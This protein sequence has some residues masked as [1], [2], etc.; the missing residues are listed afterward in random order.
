[1]TDGDVVIDG[2]GL[3]EAEVD[4]SSPREHPDT[5]ETTSS[6]D[7]PTTVARL[8]EVR[9]NDDRLCRMTPA[10]LRRFHRRRTRATTVT[11]VTHRRRPDARRDI[12]DR[13]GFAL[14]ASRPSARVAA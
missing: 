4:A 7:A 3:G 1:M 14:T 13:S 2:V 9:Q 6:E 11:K 8:V 10:S 12:G 5:S